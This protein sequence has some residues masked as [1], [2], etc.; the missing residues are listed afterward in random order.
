MAKERIL[1]LARN[2]TQLWISR[3]KN[4][5]DS[6]FQALSV[7]MMHWNNILPSMSIAIPVTGHGSL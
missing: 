2:G 5:N 4:S 1:S 6:V 3:F 7:K